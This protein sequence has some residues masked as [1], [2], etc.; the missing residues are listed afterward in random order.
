MPELIKPKIYLD[1]S[2]IGYLTSEPTRD[3]VTTSH[4]QTTR[5]WWDKHRSIFDLYVSELVTQE[6]GRG[7]PGEARKRLDIVNLIQQEL[8]ITDKATTLAQLFLK[9]K[10]LPK[11]SANDLF[12]I[13]IATVHNM[14][15]IITWNFKHIANVTMRKAMLKVCKLQGYELPIVCT[16]EE[17]IGE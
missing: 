10:A 15:C 11:K 12:H 14:D 16:P 5:E 3:L 1:T 7:D 6:A 9:E 8:K 4:Q 17:L 2:V 13:A